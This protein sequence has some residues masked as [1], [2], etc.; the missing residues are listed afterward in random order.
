MVRG[1]WMAVALGIVLGPCWAGAQE[2]YPIK[3]KDNGKG[4]TSQ[5]DKQSAEK[6]EI[7]VLDAQG[8]TVQNTQRDKN[9]VLVYRETILEKFDGQIRP[10][11]LKREYEKAQIKTGDKTETL[12]YQGKTVLIEKTEAGYRFRI[13]GGEELLG[14]DAET[15]DKEFKRLDSQPDMNKL[16][17]PAGPVKVG[18][19]WNIKVQELV[20]HLAKSGMEVEAAGGTGTA[21][22]L[23]VY[24]Q[25]G[26]QFGV[27]D[28]RIEFPLKAIGDGVQ[29]QVV[30]PGAKV[31][32]RTVLDACIDGTSC[33]GSSKYTTQV[34]ALIDTEAGGVKLKVTFTVHGDGQHA[35]KELPKK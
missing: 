8:N 3:L 21:K 24:Q 19:S 22:L 2:S 9:E 4:D 7:K 11:R 5:V 1:A 13:E 28:L 18:D 34:D 17:L 29:K 14:K 26:R 6:T 35:H 16:M 12:P 20:G 25:D 30:Q 33:S 10:T 31:N 23:R 15:L 32:L 27:I